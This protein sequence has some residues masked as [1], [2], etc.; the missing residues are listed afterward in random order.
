MDAASLVSISTA[1]AYTVPFVGG[2]LADR[3][4]GDYRTILMGFVFFYLPGVFVIASSTTPTW[5]LGT[6]SFNVKAYKLALLFLW[7]VSS[8]VISHLRFFHSIT[9]IIALIY[10]SAFVCHFRPVGTGT[11][12]AVVNIFGARQYHPILQR[13]MIE[14]FYVRFYMIINIGACLGFI[15]MP[16][17]ARNN[18][19]AAYMIPFVLLLVALVFFVAGS[20]RYVHVVPGQ[21][22]HEV[23]NGSVD[24]ESR[25]T[26]DEKPNF[27]DVAKICLLIIPFS[28]VYQQ[29]PTTC[30]RFSMSYPCHFFA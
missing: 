28:I 8:C 25:V 5:W 6:E 21:H 13:S 11:V 10:P 4:L 7:Y 16:V 1:V 19:T 3:Y 29:C 18:I 12:K 22:G 27:A 24:E 15:V 20:K 14:T 9:T 26:D 17:V 23:G 30:K 2:M